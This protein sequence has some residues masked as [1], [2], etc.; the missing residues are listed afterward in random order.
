MKKFATAVGLLF[1]L[2]GCDIA[3]LPEFADYDSAG[4]TSIDVEIHAIAMPAS[5]VEAVEIQLR[6]VLLHR[7]TDDAWIIVG[8]ESLTIGLSEEVSEV[9]I[10]GVPID[11]A[12]YDRVSI[13]VASVRVDAEGSWHAATLA[14]DVLE[15]DIDLGDAA[16]VTMDLGF[17]LEAS[18]EGSARDGWTFDPAVQLEVL[19]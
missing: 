11:H 5:G 19:D 17:D 4:T 8:P 10:E 2:T 16:A 12:R 3:T 13:E 9:V 1:S 7:A 18:L 6:N 14:V 15:L